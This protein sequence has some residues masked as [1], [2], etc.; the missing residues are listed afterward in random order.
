MKNALSLIFG[1]APLFLTLVLITQFAYGAYAGAQLEVPAAVPIFY[2]LGLTWALGWWLRRDSRSRGV[3][4]IY[5]L[6]FFLYLAWP[7][8]MPYYLIKTRGA[9]ALLIMLAFILVY[10]GATGV[11]MITA[12]VLLSLRR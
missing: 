11:G 6:G 12:G 8:V 1:P 5:D 7:I 3:P 9:K 2:K 4:S 10:G